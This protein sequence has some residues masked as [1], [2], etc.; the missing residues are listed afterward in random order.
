MLQF[1][2][3]IKQANEVKSPQGLF[4]IFLD[5]IS[6]YGFNEVRFALITDHKDIGLNAGVSIMQNYPQDW[7]KYYFEQ[8][9]DRID[10]VIT[11]GVYQTGCFAWKEISKKVKLLPKQKKCLDLGAE[12]GLHN[13]IG[14]PLRGSNNQ[15][16][17]ISIATSEKKDA[18]YVN[19]DLITAYCN[20]FYI[21]YKR[22][23]DRQPINSRN[24]VLTKKEKEVLTWAAAGKS[25][26]DIGFILGISKHT[27]NMH[28]R[29]IYTK[30]DANNRVLA[31]V[32][33][34]S[35]GLI[36]PY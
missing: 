33:A 32:K 17:G 23:H 20:H 7:M 12:A 18:C 8:E 11:Y 25:D 15:I 22:L 27:V 5:T 26:D 21:A 28:F 16:A 35:T 34:L 13:G 31:V 2:K 19:E 10:P 36:H 9:L 1:E 6:Q 4:N 14:I 29:R 30:M 24:I 3:Y